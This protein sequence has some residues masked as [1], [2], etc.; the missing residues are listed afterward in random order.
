MIKKLESDM[1]KFESDINEFEMDLVHAN[2]VN[3][4]ALEVHQEIPRT[5]V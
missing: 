2:K 1:N 5:A 4:E 3:N